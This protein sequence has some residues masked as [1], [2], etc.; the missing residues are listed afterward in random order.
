MR[1]ECEIQLMLINCLLFVDL[2]L[3]IRNPFYSR[4]SRELIYFSII[5]LVFTVT[6]LFYAR[7]LTHTDLSTTLQ[8]I[9]E[10]FQ[11]TVIYKIQSG[12]VVFIFMAT[13]IP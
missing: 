4:R 10:K 6:I 9:D 12:L 13:I 2:Y 5:A 7:Y 11:K 8:F 1:L 3:I